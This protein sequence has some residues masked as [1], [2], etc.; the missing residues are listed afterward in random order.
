MKATLRTAWAMLNAQSLA[1]IAMM[2]I[3]IAA[4]PQDE[5][6][7]RKL[8]AGAIGV[9]FG[10]LAVHVSR[11]LAV[12]MWRIL[13]DGPRTAV[14]AVGLIVVALSVLLGGLDMR[15]APTL[16]AEVP[17]GTALALFIHLSLY[18]SLLL[19]CIG[20]QLSQLIIGL[21]LLPCGISLIVTTSVF[22]NAPAFWFA[23]AALCAAG[24]AYAA[25]AGIRAPSYSRRRFAWDLR[26]ERFL[27]RIDSRVSIGDSP[28][29]ALLRSGRAG[30]T[31][32]LIAIAVLTLVA[33][34]QHVTVGR[35]NVMPLL[36]FLVL[37]IMGTGIFA[38][39]YALAFAEPAKRL[40]L[41]WAESRAELF[42]LVE[43]MAIRDVCLVAAV[44][45][46][47][48]TALAASRGL[49]IALTDGLRILVASVGVAITLAY[50]GLLF[51]ALESRWAKICGLALAA[52][53][54]IAGTHWWLAAFGVTR[55]GFAGLRLPQ[56]AVVL[57]ALAALRYAAAARWKRID[58]SHYRST[59]K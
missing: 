49:D 42:R 2:S 21:Y 16:L 15:A 27:A 32:M 43:R 31:R 7:F 44:S 36:F 39:V 3:L 47:I 48:V 51:R 35:L 54:V 10:T 50:V 57:L 25:F 55:T 59:R 58:W 19:L 9:S 41:R 37:P 12:G 14:R 23:G 26:L 52:I 22:E 5:K 53:G 34:M 38:A 20:R 33:L 29:R 28:A 13:P 18:G 30:S 6:L 40:W 1:F 45:C 11:V 4:M 17:F 46:A 24:W 8:L 56:L